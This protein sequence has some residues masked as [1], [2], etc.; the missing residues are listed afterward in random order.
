MLLDDEDH[1]AAAA[2]AAAAENKSAAVAFLAAKSE[3]KT[4]ITAEQKKMLLKTSVGNQLNKLLASLNDTEKQELAKQGDAEALQK[5]YEKASTTFDSLLSELID[6]D[7]ASL[8]GFKLRFEQ[9]VTELSKHVTT[10]EAICA[11]A[12]YLLNLRKREE[13]NDAMRLRYNHAKVVKMYSPVFGDLFGKVMAEASRDEKAGLLPVTA[14]V[15]HMNPDNIMLFKA[16][17][18]A[19]DQVIGGI[20]EFMTGSVA[21]LPDK[22]ATLKGFLNDPANAARPTAAA[23][24]KV[25]DTAGPNSSV[26]NLAAL[27]GIQEGQEY[28]DM[29]GASPWLILTR[30]LCQRMG[31]G[32]FPLQGFASLVVVV[33]GLVAFYLVPVKNLVEAGCGL[34]IIRA[35]AV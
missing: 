12:T 17:T 34:L 2:A 18:A 31:P 7:N 23:P 8:D 13:R 1:D 9:L 22:L 27:L 26:P 24:I 20:L 30:Q 3:L 33:E 4:N 19:G 32:G 28:D 14:E 6:V 25:H 21:A 35:R 16:G 5:Q 15:T 11:N 10:G 29:E